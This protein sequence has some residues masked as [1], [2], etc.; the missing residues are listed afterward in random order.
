MRSRAATSVRDCGSRVA[1]LQRYVCN[2][3]I[4]PATADVAPK[5]HEVADLGQNDKLPAVKRDRRLRD[6]ICQ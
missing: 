5:I 4:C 1:I 6:L 3:R 2:E